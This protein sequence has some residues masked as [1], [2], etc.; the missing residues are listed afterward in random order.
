MWWQCCVPEVNAS[1]EYI[2]PGSQP[3]V[4]LCL[5]AGGFMATHASKSATGLTTADA[6]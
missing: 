4:R 6:W 3:P 2:W 5:N 1:S